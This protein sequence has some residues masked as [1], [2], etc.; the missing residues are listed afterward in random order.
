MED[1]KGLIFGKVIVL[2]YDKPIYVTDKNGVSIKKNYWL[3]KCDC[4]YIFSRLAGL[5]KNRTKACKKCS[6]K[7]EKL[8][9]KKSSSYAF[10]KSKVIPEDKELYKLI[11]IR[12]HGM[13]Y[14]CYNKNHNSYK[15]Y[16]ERGISVY[17]P[18]KTSIYLFY[19]WCVNTGFN[20]DLTLD[21]IDVNGNYCPENCRWVTPEFQQN[22]RRCN[23]KRVFNGLLLT[24]SE[25]AKITGR[26][27]MQERV[28]TNRA[29]K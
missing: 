10:K 15:Y 29:N 23:I 14:R 1:L 16:G 25:I 2:E 18:W 28:L 22:N 26:S 27:Y 5:I 11:Q 17:N 24:S 7:K 3:C 9:I 8:S 12:Y 21:R 4:G 6:R 13:I 19:I 20:K